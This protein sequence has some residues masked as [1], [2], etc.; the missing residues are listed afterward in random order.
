MAAM[1]GKESRGRLPLEEDERFQLGAAASDSAALRNRRESRGGWPA[2]SLGQELT[3]G[4]TDLDMLSVL[5]SSSFD[6]RILTWLGR[7]FHQCSIH[8]P[9]LNRIE[10]PEKTYIDKR[11]CGQEVEHALLRDKA[12]YR[13]MMWKI[14]VRSST[15]LI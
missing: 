13:S 3:A 4:A 10:L 5:C 1:P 7:V 15:S 14:D 8:R 11:T 12:P 6:S 9:D 2:E